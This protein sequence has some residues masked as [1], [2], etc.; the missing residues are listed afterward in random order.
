MIPLA[1]FGARAF[2]LNGVFWGRF[3]TDICSGV[4]GIL[5]TGRIIEST[6]KGEAI[7]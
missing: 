3:I 6:A 2:G 1:Y 7:A 4:I 5:W